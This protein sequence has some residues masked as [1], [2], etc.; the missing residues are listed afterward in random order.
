MN[1]KAWLWLIWMLC[2]VFAISYHYGPGQLWL[3][4]DLIGER[5]QAAGEL[6]VAAQARQDAAYLVQLDVIKARRDAFLAGVDWQSQSEDPLALKVLEQEQRQS[7]AYSEASQ[8]WEEVTVTY[9]EAIDQMLESLQSAGNGPQTLASKDQ[10]LLESLRWAE[11]RAMVRSGLVF[12][13]VD[14]LQALLD[15]RV[16]ERELLVPVS[17]SQ[18]GQGVDGESRERL[19]VDAIREELAAAQYIGARL[20]REE[21]RAPEIWK[22][23]ANS[24]RQQ[25][26]Y[27]AERDLKMSSQ[28]NSMEVETTGSEIRQ[29]AVERG[30]VESGDSGVLSRVE[31]IQRNLEQV[32]NLEQSSSEQLEGVPLPR[33]APMARRPGD[34]EPGERPGKSPGRGELQDGPPG[35]GAGIPGPFGSGW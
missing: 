33:Q 6:A 8:S 12:N 4:R 27:L 20:L 16:S 25:Y 18:Q 28:G 3:A 23:V 35:E 9:S 13:G 14:Q 22:P 11:A 7:E 29:T 1:Q 32:L 24:A 19:P 30:S 21:G 31:R 26:R 5:I 10:Y 2:P 15:I 34:G 17:G